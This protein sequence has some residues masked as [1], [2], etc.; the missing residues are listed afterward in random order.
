MVNW[1]WHYGVGGVPKNY[2]ERKKLQ[3]AKILF[4]EYNKKKNKHI[5]TVT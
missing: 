4:G 2:E 1:R 3:F 5:Y